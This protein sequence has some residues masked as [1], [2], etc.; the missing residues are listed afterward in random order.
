M[1][2]EVQNA[3]V[4]VPRAILFSV[5]VNGALGF[6]MVIALLFCLGDLQAALQSPTGYPAMY[7]FSHGTGSVAGATTIFSIIIVVG[8]CSIT[9]QMATSSR[10]FWS[11]SRDRG[12]PG[13]R[14]WS[15][16]SHTP[17]PLLASHLTSPHNP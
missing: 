9:G 17:R 10:Q 12:V 8:A 13:W 11:F 6:A 2:E 16:V 4:V 3:P 5:I 14:F 15:K 1:A 7:I